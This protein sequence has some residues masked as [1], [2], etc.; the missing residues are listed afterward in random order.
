VAGIAALVWAQ[1]PAL[2]HRDVRQVLLKSCQPSKE[3][4]GML[5]K[6]KTQ[7]NFI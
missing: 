5:E 2:S 3:L 1:N 7:N 4:T 6:I